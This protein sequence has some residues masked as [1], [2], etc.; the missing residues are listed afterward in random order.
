MYLPTAVRNLLTVVFAASTA[1]LISRV[2]S[3]SIFNFN[4]LFVFSVFSETSSPTLH[5][6]F[7]VRYNRMINNIS[8][9]V[10]FKIDKTCS[11]TR[12]YASSWLTQVTGTLRM[13]ICIVTQCIR[14]QRNGNVLL[15]FSNKFICFELCKQSLSKAIFLHI[16]LHNLSWTYLFGSPLY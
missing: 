9:F 3:Y 14:S 2:H 1:L 11:S 15:P 5:H 12:Q 7:N 16:S 6:A 8:Q 10:L 4:I 13:S